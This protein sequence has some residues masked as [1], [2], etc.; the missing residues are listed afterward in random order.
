MTCQLRDEPSCIQ[1]SDIYPQASVLHLIS[2]LLHRSC[3]TQKERFLHHLTW[4][5]SIIAAWLTT[6]CLIAGGRPGAGD[7]YLTALAALDHV[8][9]DLGGF[10]VEVPPPSEDLMGISSRFLTSLEQ[11]SYSNK[12]LFSAEVRMTGPLLMHTNGA[13]NG[14]KC[15]ILVMY[16][17]D[18]D[19]P[20]AA[21]ALDEHQQ[22][23]SIMICISLLDYMDLTTES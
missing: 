17:D 15:P 8:A 1:H 2:S 11:Q 5:S 9:P 21:R 16:R 22:H 13:R 4:S 7:L 18:L 12:T 3:E 10:L 14:P 23:P 6:V 19:G 20:L